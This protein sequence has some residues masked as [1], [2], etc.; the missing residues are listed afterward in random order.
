MRKRR[1]ASLNDS[2]TGSIG[3]GNSTRPSEG[4]RMRFPKYEYDDMIALQY[5]LLTQGLQV[6][7]LRLLMVSPRLCICECSCVSMQGTSMGAMHSW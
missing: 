2:L 5:L 7:H 1:C 6:N 3:H 4:L